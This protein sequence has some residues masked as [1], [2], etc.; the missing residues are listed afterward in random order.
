MQTCDHKDQAS[1]YALGLLDEAGS[2]EFEQHL[3]SCEVCAVE[4]RE[5]SEI[6]VQLAGTI[7][8]S[9]PPSSLR[10]RV[11][12]EA[13]LPRGVAALIRGQKMNWQPTEFTGV[14]VARLYEDPVRGELTALVRMAPGARYP[15][16]RHT[17]LEHCYV[18]E[19]D[20]IFEDYVMTAGDYSAGTPYKDHSAA[21]TKTGCLLFMVNNLRDQAHAH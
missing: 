9:S 12:N 8:P 2:S 16:H 19:G 11:L 4:L 18:I 13:V 10:D 7:S 14:S 6:A 20:L 3:D 15:S 1:L 5:S 21:T 17:S